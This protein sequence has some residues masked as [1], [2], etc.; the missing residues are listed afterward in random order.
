MIKTKATLIRTLGARL[1]LMSTACLALTGCYFDV[2]IPE[3]VSET[4]VISFAEDIQPIFNATCISCHNG[5]IA[6]PNLTS[7]NA[8][9]E[10]A[11]GGYLSV[12]SPEESGLIQ[13][14]NSEHPY[15]GALTS[16][17]TQKLLNWMTQGALDN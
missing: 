11:G 9:D 10:L 15:A 7:G 2:I 6:S 12:S 13:K 3:E 16:A 4:E 17:E 14:L 8:Y 1:L 5:N